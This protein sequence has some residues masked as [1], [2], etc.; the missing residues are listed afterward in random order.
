MSTFKDTLINIYA[1][2]INIGLMANRAVT[3][4]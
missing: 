1:R 4:A 3:P 2:L